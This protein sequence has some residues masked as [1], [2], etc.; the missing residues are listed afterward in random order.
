MD[1]PRTSLR[2]TAMG[3]LTLSGI[4][5]RGYFIPYRYAGRTNG[6]GAGRYTEIEAGF[7][8]RVPA[9]R[10]VLHDVERYA[11]D[12]ADIGRDP[13]P[14]PRFA[15]DWFPPLDAVVAYTFVRDL[16]P[17]RIVEVGSGHSTRF[18]ARA[19]ADGALETK[20][21]AIDP[22]PR[23]AV[24]AID[25][26]LDR[27]TVQEADAACFAALQ[28]GDILFIDS[29]HILMPGSDVDVLLNR[30]LPAL[31]P[32]VIVQIHDVFLPDDYPRE[33]AWRGYNEQTA[34]GPLIASGAVEVLFAS[35]FVATHLRDALAATVVSRLPDAERR[36]ESSLWVKIP[37]P[38][39]A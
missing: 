36:Y 35:R 32:G 37:Q 31:A 12:L 7:M 24:E 15:Q 1:W 28:A 33:W 16:K 9:F 29:S 22:E 38:G 18:L 30:V 21:I 17:K 23:A 13:P 11:G 3:L 27:R 19:V 5:K 20:M 6:A 4:A 25:V 14:A 26:H 34:L 10:Q 8:A 39:T 2:R